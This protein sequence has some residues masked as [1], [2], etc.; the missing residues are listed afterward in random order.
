MKIKEIWQFIK[1]VIWPTAKPF[2]CASREE[3]E[4]LIVWARNHERIANA[5]ENH[6]SLD[7]DNIPVFVIRCINA[8]DEE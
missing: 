2:I 8:I 7:R 1:T 6:M 4:E 5:A 3:A